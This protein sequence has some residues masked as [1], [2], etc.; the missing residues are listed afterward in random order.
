MKIGL[1]GLGNMG[2]GMAANIIKAGHALVVYNRTPAKAEAARITSYNVCYTKLLR[3]IS[4]RVLPS[5]SRRVP[6]A[7]APS[8]STVSI[9]E[10]EAEMRNNFV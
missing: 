3:A 10:V 6:S 4:T 8:P 9:Q 5:R 1:I 7:S 2:S